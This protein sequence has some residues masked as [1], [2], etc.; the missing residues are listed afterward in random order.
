MTPSAAST[1]Q[2]PAPWIDIEVI[3]TLVCVRV[4]SRYQ[5]HKRSTSSFVSFPSLYN[6]ING[7][8]FISRFPIN[9]VLTASLVMIIFSEAVEG[10]VNAAEV[11]YKLITSS[12]IYIASIILVGRARMMPFNTVMSSFSFFH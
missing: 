8:P 10:G 2:L 12:Y 3:L 9:V 1:L 11:T 5:L 4:P 6:N 7:T